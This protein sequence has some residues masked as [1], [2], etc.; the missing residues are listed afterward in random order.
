MMLGVYR[1]G[2]AILAIWLVVSP[3]QAPLY[4]K[5]RK[6]DK[7]LKEGQK[8]ESAQDWDKALGL[9]EQALA[10]DFSDPGY[11]LFVR[12]ARFQTS[13]RHIQAGMKLRQ[14]GNLEGA[15]A[16][17]QRAF[18]I[19]PSSSLAEQEAKRTYQMIQRNKKEGSAQLEE[20]KGL[21]P[22]QVARRGIEEKMSLL[23]SVPELKPLNPQ[24][25]NLKMNNQNARVLFETAAKLAGI[26]VLF[27]P[28]FVSSLQGKTFSLDITNSTIEEA[29]DYLSLLTKAFW[30]P[31]S[32]N[33]IFVTQDQQTKR[34]DFED[35]VVKVFYLQ[36]VTAAQEL[37]EIAAALRAVTEIR[38]LLPYTSQMAIMVRGTADQVDLA[39]KLIYDLDKPKSEV[40][41]DIMVMEANRT[42]TRTLTAT[43]ANGADPGI[44]IPITYTRNGNPSTS[45]GDNGDNN[46]GN[47]NAGL[48]TLSRLSKISTNDF[49]V[50]VP[51]G[52][53][54]ALLNQTDTKVHQNP[55]LR[56]LDNVKATLKIGDRYPYATGSFQTGVATTVS[57]L[58]STQF[59]FA[60]VGVNVDILPKIHG[61][62]E[63]SLHV[64]V[65]LSTIRTTVNVGGLSQPVIGQRKIFEDIR[66]KEGEVSIMGGLSSLTDSRTTVGIPGLANIPGIGFL[67][68]SK[69][70]DL[71]KSELLLVMV[72]RIVRAPDIN[73]V[74]LRTIAT[75]NDQFVKLNYAPRATANPPAAATTP[76]P[77]TTPAVPAPANAPPAATAPQ[78]DAGQT[79]LAF[80]PGTEKA[81]VGAPITVSLEI[82]DAKDLFST[83]FRINYDPKLLKL[84]DVVRGSMMSSDN[85]PVSF[86]RDVNSG[87]VKISRLPGAPGING[88]GELVKLTFQPLAKG[89]A[90]VSVEDAL[91]QDSKMQ[92]VN[93]TRTPLT[94]TIE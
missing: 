81:T 65:E 29:L 73:E 9:Y 31:I 35:N 43:L 8:A 82:S 11:L 88:S 23:R 54:Q 63:V 51:G 36:N 13:Q 83:P 4:A 28:D 47:S 90:T 58:V 3:F 52:I 26:N 72:P 67:F 40:V 75:G 55:Q 37:N 45:T 64:E 50:A 71:N 27:D 53:V 57:P 1:L 21:T 78:A 86:T 10:T 5:T 12:R 94:I 42:K 44:K 33:A 66:L 56:T 6:G 30:K 62:N 85:Q 69:G 80:A 24:V 60:E 68:G 46:N 32:P 89:T 19:D 79:K 59:Q 16:E 22:A 84:T 70:L 17:F 2:A 38:R 7:L 91:L 93:A 87:V 76:A 49:S 48:A 74:N 18:A 20:E 39:Q 14:E 61:N 41:I 25:S 15:L 92:P 77:G 34:R